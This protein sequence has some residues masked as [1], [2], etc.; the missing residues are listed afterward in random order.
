MDN[1]WAV[2]AVVNIDSS[3]SCLLIQGTSDETT[4]LPNP[5]SSVSFPFHPVKSAT[6]TPQANDLRHSSC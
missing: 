2:S 6:R 5:L 1:L 3:Y 4:S